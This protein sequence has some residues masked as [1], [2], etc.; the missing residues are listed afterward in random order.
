M[1]PKVLRTGRIAIAAV[2]ACLAGCGDDDGRLETHPVSG[3]VVVNGEPAAGCTVAF[4]PLDPELKGVVM[5]G[6]KTDEAGVFRL[7]TYETG[8]GAPTGEYGVTLRWEATKW[9]GMERELE[10]DPVQPIGPDRLMG[11]YAS[12]EKSGLKAT[13]A[14]GENELEPFRLEGVRLLAGSE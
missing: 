4:V 6:G 12:P 1:T 5:P 8:D 13:I 14:E 2:A 9:P 11:R 7:T 10:I 3:Q